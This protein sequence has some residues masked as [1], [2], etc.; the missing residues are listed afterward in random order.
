[1]SSSMLYKKSTILE[2]FKDLAVR[3][4]LHAWLNDFQ[5][6]RD[7]AERLEARKRKIVEMKTNGDVGTVVDSYA[8]E[9]PTNRQ[10]T[11][12]RF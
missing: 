11:S 1:M 3:S 10:R 7:M 5:T 2:I 6:P 8:A 4:K 12:V 9:P